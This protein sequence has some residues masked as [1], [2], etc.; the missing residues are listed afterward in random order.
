LEVV[1]PERDAPE[2]GVGAFPAPDD[3]F[4]PDDDLDEDAF[5]HPGELPTDEP[6][7]APHTGL[8]PKAEA[9]RKRSATGAILTG[10]AL[11]LQRVFEKEREEPSI[12]MQVSGDPPQDLPVEADVQ[13]GRPR[14][15]VVSIRPWL[16]DGRAGGPGPAGTQ[17]V[18]PA[19][20]E[21]TVTPAVPDTA[22]GAGVHAKGDPE[23]GPS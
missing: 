22:G 4:Q 2:P 17:A 3:H 21:S 14:Q 18:P 16:L 13:H 11:G 20:P 9:W 1:A 8:P 23:P 10:F 5:G 6:E 7:D 12:V 19:V 15:S